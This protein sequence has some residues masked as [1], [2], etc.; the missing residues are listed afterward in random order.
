MKRHTAWAAVALAM[1]TGAAVADEG[2]VPL[3][4]PTVILKP[5]SYVVTRDIQASDIVLSIEVDGV[6]VDLNGFTL[7][8]T[9][10]QLPAVQVAGSAGV[11]SGVTIR[12][13]R[14]TGG[15]HGI[16][17]TAGVPRRIEVREVD[18]ESA[19]S[20]GILIETPNDVVLCDGSVRDV[21]YG[22]QLGTSGLSAL[23]S[24]AGS[25]DA[26]IV[27]GY[28]SAAL[29]N[30]LIC[31]CTRCWL[32]DVRVALPPI[33]PDPD[34][35]GRIRLV[36]APGS[37]IRGLELV[38]GDPN[39]QPSIVLERSPGTLLERNVISGSGTPAEGALGIL[40]DG[41]SNNLRI[42]G[43][44]L[45]GLGADAIQVD[46]AG[47]QIYDNLISGNA[48]NGISL[49]G[50]NALVDAN[51]IYGNGGVGLFFGPNAL[52]HAFRD[53][54]LRGNT[55]GA[56]GGNPQGGDDVGGNIP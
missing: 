42:V 39:P 48:G 4:E 20:T 13:G 33:G 38:M 5:G 52:L 56:V 51:Q 53:N 9:N 18:I 19:T 50:K 26:A 25:V 11:A 22:I 21:L 7:S 40:A 36:D 23:G 47:A 1:L 15:L 6:T 10:P 29:R 43:N 45:S 32:D 31:A 46:G 27:R 16:H 49:L 55:A 44:V 41:A 2:R 34:P 12:N 37:V 30:D 17:G 14:V 28:L 54:M 35:S 24:C 8:S 3:W